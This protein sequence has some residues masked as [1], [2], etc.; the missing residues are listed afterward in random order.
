MPML[1]LEVETRA[2]GSV[3]LAEADQ[4]SRRVEAAVARAVPAAGRVHCDA[5]A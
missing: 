5:H 2:D 3:P 4:I 1:L